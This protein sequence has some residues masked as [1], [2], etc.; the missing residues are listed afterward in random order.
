MVYT[1]RSVSWIT[2]GLV[3]I[4]LGVFEFHNVS[5]AVLV[6]A[7]LFQGH[8]LLIQ[9]KPSGASLSFS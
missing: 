9:D 8:F 5:L 2:H 7:S 1:T 3:F 4:A 6:S